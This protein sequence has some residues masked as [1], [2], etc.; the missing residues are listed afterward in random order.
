MN[1]ENVNIF[2]SFI[3]NL[4]HKIL[5]WIIIFS[6]FQY[7]DVFPQNNNNSL[8]KQIN[9][10]ISPEFSQKTQIS[11]DVYN[12]TLDKPLY[13]K[14]E[15]LLLRPA[16]TI[17]ILTSAAAYLFIDGYKFQT[18]VYH[19]G[20]IEDSV[21]YG[22][23]YIYGGCDPE[24]NIKDLDSLTK[25]IK[26]YG[27]KEIRGNIYA[28]TSF[29]DSE[30]WG[31]GWMWDDDPQP[32]AAYFSP[33]NINRNVIRV[34]A[35]PGENGKPAIIEFNP[36]TD[37]FEVINS[38]KT[39]PS[40]KSNLKMTRD[41]FNRKNVI[42]VR[43]NISTASRPL[44]QTFS[45]FD[46]A[47]YFLSVLK[48]SISRNGIDFK[49]ETHFINLPYEVEEIFTFERDID[50]V[51]VNVNKKSDNLAAEMV[52]RALAYNYLAKPASAKNGIK[53]LDSLIT[54]S[55]MNP[56]EY[57]IVDGSGLSFYN[58]LSAEVV[59]SVLKYIYYNEEE[60]FVK[61]Y[62]SFPISG[63]DGTL[64]NRMRNSSI[65]RKVRGKTG[66]LSG[67]SALSGYIHNKNNELVTFS[68]LI[69]NFKNGAKAARD[70]Q[71]KIC[72]IIYNYY[73]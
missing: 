65:Y 15:K 34:T 13:S 59:T 7:S 6:F 33:L 22:S 26:N 48:E 3:E 46:P 52:L 21:C 32:F 63:Y 31:E 72:E 23:L 11:I 49:G 71:D 60:I 38:S 12:L 42:K 20:E 58:L 66:S 67:V 70:L 28:D 43:G 2:N 19:D 29:M 4:I 25:E 69:Q 30:I 24:F 64:K 68:V 39:I 14:N 18:S 62:N 47:S 27:I 45:I 55:G 10:I 40:G 50:S 9:R 41:W 73:E 61:L 53:L 57:R 36:P 56:E 1:T 37:F 54:L 35:K 17:K 5:F 51:I 8:E 16:S 44:N